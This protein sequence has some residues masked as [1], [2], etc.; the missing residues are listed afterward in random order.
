MKI[1][2]SD[3]LDF[4]LGQVIRLHRARVHKLFGKLGLYRGQPP[5]LFILWEEDGRTQKEIADRLH[6]KPATITDGLKRM[7]TTS[8]AFPRSTIPGRKCTGSEASSLVLRPLF[9]AG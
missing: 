1:A 7:R 6:L 9:C 5:I 8:C 4:L 3:S 2:N